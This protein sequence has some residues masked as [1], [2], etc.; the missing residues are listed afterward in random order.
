LR[1]RATVVLEEWSPNFRIEGSEMDRTR[2]TDPL[3]S[4][5]EPLQT[6]RKWRVEL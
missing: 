1:R 6:A 3:A 2:L 5:P 4:F